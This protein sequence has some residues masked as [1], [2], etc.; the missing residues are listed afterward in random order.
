MPV[1]EIGG[2]KDSNRPTLRIL[3][4]P[5]PVDQTPHDS[6]LNEESDHN[7]SIWG[8]QTNP[9]PITSDDEGDITEDEDPA[10]DEG[11]QEK[12]ELAFGSAFEKFEEYE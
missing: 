7:P 5:S 10:S 12:E 6:E 1:T 2:Q 11:E 9:W 8:T 3:G 4:S